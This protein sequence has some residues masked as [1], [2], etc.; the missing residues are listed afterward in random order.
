M[1]SP[2]SSPLTGSPNASIDAIAFDPS[3]VKLQLKTKVS[4]VAGQPPVG[5]V[6]FHLLRPIL[7]V[8]FHAV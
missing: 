5:S 4:V 7:P 2:D 8:S 1:L 6:A 3:S